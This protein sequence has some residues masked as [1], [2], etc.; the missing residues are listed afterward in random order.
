MSTGEVFGWLMFIIF[1][2][3]LFFAAFGSTSITEETVEEYISNLMKD[4]D[5]G[6]R[7]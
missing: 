7:R 6:V 5:T 3:I 1:I 4:E 2:S